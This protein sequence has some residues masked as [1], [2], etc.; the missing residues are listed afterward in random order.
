[1][2]SLMDDH[3][4]SPNRGLSNFSYNEPLHGQ[5]EQRDWEIHTQLDNGHR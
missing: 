2:V 5:G 1:M 3:E 4:R